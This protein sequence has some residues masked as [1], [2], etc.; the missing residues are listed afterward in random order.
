M[1]L[2]KE[3]YLEFSLS[4]SIAMKNGI[5]NIAGRVVIS[6]G[7]TYT[8]TQ[9][10]IPL[11]F[12]GGSD[13]DRATII[14]NGESFVIGNVAGKFV[15]DLGGSGETTFSDKDDYIE[16]EIGDSDYRITFEGFGSILFSVEARNIMSSSSSSSSS[17]EYSS[18]SSSSSGGYSSSSSS[19]SGG[20]SSSSSSSSSEGYSSSSSSSSSS[21]GG[22]SSSSSSSSSEGYSSSSSSSSSEGY[23]SSSSSSSYGFIDKDLIAH[24]KMN[25]NAANTTVTDSQENANGT[26]IDAA[27]DPNT[28]AHTTTGKINEALTFDGSDDYI[29][30]TDWAGFQFGASQDFSVACWFKTSTT[31]TLKRLVSW[32]NSA[33]NPYWAVRIETSNY[34]RCL[35]RDSGG[36]LGSATDSINVCDGGWHHAVATMDRDGAMKIYLDGNYRVQDSNI[37]DVGDLDSDQPLVIGCRYEGSTV[38][39]VMNGDIDDVR[40]YNRALTQDDITL[41]WNN[42]NGTEE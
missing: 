19:S 39:Q 35:F 37:S 34:L 24:Y 11:E 33:S 3:S 28:D 36:T 17:G 42:G 12:D 2:D 1:A 29:N 16:I 22:H 7:D 31:G 26:F 41:L 21:S 38:T 18:S 30:C 14:V 13:G 9:A 10:Y 6:N 4:Y 32:Q 15:W 27:G 40:I 23:S 8:V 25:D 20:Y 5:V